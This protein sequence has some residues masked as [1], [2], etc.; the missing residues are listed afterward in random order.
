MRQK[1]AERAARP[2]RAPAG[3]ASACAAI[4]AL[5]AG[6]GAAM[7]ASAANYALIMTIGTYANPRANL[8]GIDLDA[9]N[10]GRIAEAMGVPASNVEYVSD[11]KLTVDGVREAFDRT[12]ARIQRGD[13]VFVYYSGH[14]TQYSAGAGK[15]AEG[16]MAYDMRPYVDLALQESLAQLGQKAG[17]VVMMNDSC[18]SGGQAESRALHLGNRVDKVWKLSDEGPGYKCGEPINL[19]FFARSIVPVVKQA[20]SNLLYVAA[21]QDNEVARASNAG[22]AATLAWIGC[23]TGKSDADHS[24]VLDGNEI[25]ACAQQWLDRNNFNQH[26]TLVGNKDL[27]LAFVGTGASAGEGSIAGAAGSGDHGGNG[28]NGGN[29]GNADSGDGAAATPVAAARFLDQIRHAASPGI[30]VSLSVAT[31][32]MRISKDALDFSVTTSQGGY[33]TVL[34]V[35]SDGQTFNRLFPNDVDQNNRVP[36][37]TLRLPR[38]GWAVRSGGPAGTSYLMAVVSETPRDFAKGFQ[39]AGPF[40]TGSG[41]ATARTLY[42]AATGADNDHPGR[43]GASEVVPVAE[44]DN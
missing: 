24:G 27:P 13:N 39:A 7:P 8:P 30:T 22:S 3:R 12:S 10:A 32:K 6:G 19:K 35:G 25:R 14:G 38:A 36:A 28:D 41:T 4:L 2:R 5:V 26:V 15:C 34:Q 16:M 29:V 23:L 9:R 42:V 40:R 33:L 20:G 17:Q 31:P 18:F 11:D 37:G 21:S 43:F 44:V 1:F